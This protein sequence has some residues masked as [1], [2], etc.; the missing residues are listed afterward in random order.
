M[1]RTPTYAGPSLEDCCRGG[2]DNFEGVGNSPPAST[3]GA[4]TITRGG[5]RDP[6]MTGGRRNESRT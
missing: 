4:T 2:P 6:A 1:S 3:D 5:Q